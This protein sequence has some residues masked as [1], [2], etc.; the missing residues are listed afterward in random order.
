MKYRII[1][2]GTTLYKIEKRNTFLWVFSYWSIYRTFPSYDNLYIILTDWIGYSKK[3]AEDKIAS[4]IKR[5]EDE[6]RK[7]KVIT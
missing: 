7:W 6:S 1:N 4:L 3:E 5:D 2:N